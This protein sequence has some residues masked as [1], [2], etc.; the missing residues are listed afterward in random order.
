MVRCARLM[1]VHICVRSYETA[2][3]VLF[4]Q[5]CKYVA[6]FSPLNGFF[7]CLVSIFV[8]HIANFHYLCTRFQ[9]PLHL[10]I[11]MGRNKYSEK[12]IQ[13]IRKLLRIKC[14]GNRAQ[15]KEVRHILR[16]DYEFNISD[17]NVQGQPFGEE[18]LDAC[19]RRHAIIILDDATIEAMKAKRAR[20][21]QRDAEAAMQASV[22]AGETTDWQQAMREWEEWE[23][24][25]KTDQ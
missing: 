16:T 18:E 1:H 11:I 12:E 19:L 7:L 22:E 4:F 6:I 23:K 17:F 10:A 21:R 9:T 8:A 25:E 13:A 20:D 14:S 3:I 15:Q 5:L 2:K 24:K